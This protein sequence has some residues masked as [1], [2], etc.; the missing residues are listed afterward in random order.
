MANKQHGTRQKLVFRGVTS[1]ASP[2]PPAPPARRRDARAQPP[3]PGGA[4]PARRRQPRKLIG[5]SDS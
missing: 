2:A 4:T 3:V 5:S 1:T